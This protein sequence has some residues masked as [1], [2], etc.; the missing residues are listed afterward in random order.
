MDP[1]PALPAKRQK[2]TSREPLERCRRHPPGSRK[3][4]RRVRADHRLCTLRRQGRPDRSAGPTGLAIDGGEG[5]RA[6]PDLTARWENPIED[7]APITAAR[8]RLCPLTGG[9]VPGG[10]SSRRGHHRAPRPACARRG[11]VRVVDLAGGRGGQ[12]RV[13]PSPTNANPSRLHCSA[14]F[15]STR[16]IPLSRRGC[17]CR[18]STSSRAL[19]VATSRC[20]DALDPPGTRCQRRSR[21]ASSLRSST[22][23]ASEPG[24]YEFRAFARDRAGN[25][26]STIVAPAARR[27]ASTCPCASEPDY[28]QGSHGRLVSAPGFAKN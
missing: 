1:P 3:G 8:W 13:D 21:A 20:A 28:A 24:A 14:W 6:D 22:T 16:W 2:P 25:E 12:P 7:H 4:H 17:L 15:S 5:W 11:R 10:T 26:S 9:L 27:W 18:Q 23:S 19:Q